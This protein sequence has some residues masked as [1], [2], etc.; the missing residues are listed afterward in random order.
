MPSSRQSQPDPL[1]ELV[2]QQAALQ[3]RIDRLIAQRE[4]PPASSRSQSFSTT[5]SSPTCPVPVRV[6]AMQRLGDRCGGS[7]GSRGRTSEYESDRSGSRR[8]S[9]SEKLAATPSLPAAGEARMNVIREG[10]SERASRQ[11]SQNRRARPPLPPAHGPEQGTDPRPRGSVFDR[12]SHKGSVEE[13]EKRL[14]SEMKARLAEMMKTMGHVGGSSAAALVRNSK[15]PFAEHIQSCQVPEKFKL[16]ALESYDGTSDPV[17]HWQQ[18]G[19][20]MGL[21]NVPDGVV[22]RA[23]VTTLKGAAR[24]WCNSL[25]PGSIQSSQELG[26]KFIFHF[27]GTRKQSKPSTYLFT[28][29]QRSTEGLKDYASRF[30]QESLTV[31]DLNEGVAVA[32][33][34]EGVSS[35]YCLMT[36]ARMA[37]KN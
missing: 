21:Q 4:T 32:A 20:I 8:E 36:L 29:K 13:V 30:N 9:S 27:L 22:C 37:P 14:M 24:M 15:S 6:P 1:I 33:F 3:V 35:P 7:R 16:P 19:N 10:H 11:Q 26:T 12:I 23:F 17:D 18:Y 2:A 34:M 31:T 28:I 25:P 5:E